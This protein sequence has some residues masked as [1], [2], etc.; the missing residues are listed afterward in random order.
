MNDILILSLLEFKSIAI[1]CGRMR[2]E[3]NILDLEKFAKRI[4]TEPARLHNLIILVKLSVG[5]IFSATF[6]R[7][8]SKF[9]NY[10]KG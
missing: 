8:K 3:Y 10:L 9:L 2:I 5:L 1:L 4:W 7:K 6:R